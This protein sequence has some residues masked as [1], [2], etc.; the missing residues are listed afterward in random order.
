MLAVGYL[1]HFEKVDEYVYLD[2]YVEKIMNAPVDVIVLN[3]PDLS[4]V[5][6][7]L[8]TT[9]RHSGF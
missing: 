1:R 5:S 6:L 9:L 2:I 7:R 8:V 4:D 3:G